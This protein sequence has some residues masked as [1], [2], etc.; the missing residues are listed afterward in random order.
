MAVIN[1]GYGSGA[2]WTPAKPLPQWLAVKLR[3]KHPLS[4]IVV[5]T[6]CDDEG[7]SSLDEETR[8]ELQLSSADG[9]WRTIE[10]KKQNYYIVWNE[11]INRWERSETHVLGAAKAT[12][13]SFPETE[14]DR[15][16]LLFTKG[17]RPNILEIEAYEE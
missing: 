8:Y 11:K 15:F 9:N 2:R 7:V 10:A 16:R 17:K 6:G 3:N 12:A 1:G 14:A 5:V 4:R 13:H